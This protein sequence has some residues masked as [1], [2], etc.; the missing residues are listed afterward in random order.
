MK[1]AACSTFDEF[2]TMSFNRQLGSGQLYKR[3]FLNVC[4]Q[5]SVVVSSRSEQK[6]RINGYLKNKALADCPSLR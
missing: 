4:N 5:Q 3:A 6:E 1:G 2:N